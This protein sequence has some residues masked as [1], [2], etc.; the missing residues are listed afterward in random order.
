MAVCR[1]CQAP[2]EGG[3]YCSACGAPLESEAPPLALL[4]DEPRRPE[5]VAR[6]RRRRDW[7]GA[8]AVASAVVVA[9]VV[10]DRAASGRTGEPATPPTTATTGPTTTTTMTTT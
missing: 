6:P 9:L 7:I 8:V 10:A 1:S 2:V 3:R 4:S 5:R